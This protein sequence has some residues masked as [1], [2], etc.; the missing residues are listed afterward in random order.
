[1]VLVVTIGLP[2]R[3]RPLLIVMTHDAP[4]F[5]RPTEYLPNDAISISLDMYNRL[6][7]CFGH[8]R[9]GRRIHQEYVVIASYGHI[10]GA[11][12]Y[13]VI[14]ADGDAMGVF[15]RINTIVIALNDIS[16]VHPEL[17]VFAAETL[18]QQQHTIKIRVLPKSFT[19]RL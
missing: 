7:I 11:P 16:V 15:G 17:L 1:L 8:G 2:F 18:G 12:D 3:R 19:F 14:S 5:Q 10:F 6:V 9:L 4:V 13:I